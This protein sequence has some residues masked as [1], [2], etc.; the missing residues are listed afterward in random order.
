MFLFFCRTGE[1]ILEVIM[2]NLVSSASLTGHIFVVEESCQPPPAK[3]MGP[4]K[5][6]VQVLYM[7]LLDNYILTVILGDITNKK[8]SVHCR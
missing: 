4:N 6:Q 3:N 7:P 2:F 8:V 1:Y 5:I